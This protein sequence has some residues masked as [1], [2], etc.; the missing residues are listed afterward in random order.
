M[1]IALGAG[2]PFI[3][4]GSLEVYALLLCGLI[5]VGMF[6]MPRRL[7]YDDR[8][9]WGLLL[10]FLALYSLYPHYISIR[11]PGLP[12]ISPIRLALV[13][14][15]FVWLYALRASL[16]MQS[17]L[18]RYVRENR[19]FF[20]LLAVYIGAQTLSIPTAQGPAQ[21]FSKFLLFQ[22][23]WT[24]PLLAILSL[25]SSGGR[26]RTIALAFVA[27]ALFQCLIG[28]IEARIERVVWIDLLPPG[29]SADDETLQVYLSGWVR[30]EAYRV[31]GS[32]SVSLI[33]AEFLVMMLPFALFTAI[34]GRGWW[35]R[36]LGAVT[37]LAILPAQFLSGS[38]LGMVGTLVVFL[39]LLTIYVLRF[40]RSNRR[41]P[42]GP[43]LVMLLPLAFLTFA[44]AFVSSPRLQTMTIG[45]GQH[46]DS[47][48]TRMVQIEMG[49]PRI[50]ERPV[51]GHGIGLGAEALGYR[52]LAGNPV[53]DNYMLSM[54][55][56]VGLVGFVAYFGMIA[57]S[58]W[59]GAKLYLDP[60]AGPARIGGAIALAL[61]AFIVIKLV[62]SQTDTHTMVFVMM[63][64]VL[65]LRR[66]FDR[67]Q[68]VPTAFVE[69]PEAWRIAA[70]HYPSKALRAQA[71][72]AEPSR[73]SGRSKVAR[74]KVPEPST[75]I[76]GRPR[77]GATDDS[78]SGKAK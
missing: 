51:F 37:A 34:D 35:V 60:R 62:L 20:I 7:T 63:A 11:L 69:P 6:A 43:A 70:R 72:G 50:A 13:S 71:Q 26:L 8:L 77:M 25:L 55:L 52:N 19:L 46:Q 68:A 36:A 38:R 1:G 15:L 33:Y 39:F 10:V 9:C 32:F 30:A 78:N 42:M 44:V 17:N 29:F 73:R 2:L 16:T 18:A 75:G 14:L 27:L 28:F 49:L 31:K 12:W 56:E 74:P 21:A 67:R 47:T 59:Q 76:G 54:L 57:W 3:I 61:S 23:Y 53:I 58:I 41:S 66:G 5:V 40:W 64:M 65:V 48:A 22:L 24:F 4:S 45:G